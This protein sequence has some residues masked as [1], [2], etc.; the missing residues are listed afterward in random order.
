MRQLSSFALCYLCFVLFTT[1]AVICTEAL[2]N[3][4]A[5]LVNSLAA[6]YRVSAVLTLCCRSKN[7]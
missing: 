2:L 7:K 5:L 6:L 3:K 1:I 4:Y